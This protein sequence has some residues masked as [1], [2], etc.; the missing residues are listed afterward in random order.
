MVTKR[1]EGAYLKVKYAFS[2]YSYGVRYV[3]K[4]YIEFLQICDNILLVASLLV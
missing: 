2:S 1:Y 4:L 3:D